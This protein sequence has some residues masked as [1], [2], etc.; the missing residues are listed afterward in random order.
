MKRS[1]KELLVWVDDTRTPAAQQYKA[2]HP[3]E[4]IRIVTIPH[5][6]GY[7]PTKISLADQAKSGWP[8]VV[9]LDACTFDGKIYCLRNDIAPTV[10]WYDAKLMRQYHYT[11]PK[12]WADYQRIGL[13]AAKDHPG[14]IVGTVNGKYGAGVYF[15]SSGCPTRDTLSLTQVHID[16][17]QPSCTRVAQLLQPVVRS[18]LISANPLYTDA[19]NGEL[20]LQ[21]GSP[22][23]GGGETIPGLTGNAPDQG[24]YQYADAVWAAG[25]SLP[26][27]VERVQHGRW[28]AIA[29]EGTNASA[30]VDGDIKTRW[31][32]A[33]AMAVGQSLTVDLGAAKTFDRLSLDAGRDTTGQPY[34]F[35]VSVSAD[36]THWGA[37]VAQVSG[38]SFT[39]DAVFRAVTARYLRR[40]SARGWLGRTRS[41]SSPRVLLRYPLTGGQ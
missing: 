7:V 35:S 6:A 26:G 37:P 12:T 1:R 41:F 23:I 24:A 11:V 40:G 18:N 2:A 25:C 15:G 28:T 3:G 36:G 22:A 32:G 29:S 17:T 20:W 21:A 30:G 16:L 10:L 33:A 5:D 4:D 14:T 8:D 39:Q 13:Q 38:R 27:C 19:L 31:T 34:G 9:F